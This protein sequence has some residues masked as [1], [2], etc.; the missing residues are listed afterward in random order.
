MSWDET[1]PSSLWQ[2]V[3]G[4]M[5][6]RPHPWRK[7]TVAHGPCG[8]ALHDSNPQF[9]LVGLRHLVHGGLWRILEPFRNQ[10]VARRAGTDRFP[11]WEAQHHPELGPGRTSEE[12]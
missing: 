9:L 12:H 1:T 8:G 3:H 11:G 10:L 2:E 4:A 7:Q 5:G 6:H